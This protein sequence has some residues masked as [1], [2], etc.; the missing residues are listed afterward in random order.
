MFISDIVTKLIT[1]L[2]NIALRRISLYSYF[3]AY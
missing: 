3:S 1:A 2:E